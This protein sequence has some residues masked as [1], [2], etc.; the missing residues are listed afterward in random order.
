MW[1]LV[2]YVLFVILLILDIRLVK[3]DTVGYKK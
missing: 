2:L 1:F 3:S